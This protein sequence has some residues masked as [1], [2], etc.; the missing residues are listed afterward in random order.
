M[1][2]INW[3]KEYQLRL[4]TGY[5]DPSDTSD[6]PRL[7]LGTWTGLGAAYVAMLGWSLS[8]KPAKPTQS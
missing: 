4:E 7:P 6:A 3:L 8:R 1:S 5:L 2:Q